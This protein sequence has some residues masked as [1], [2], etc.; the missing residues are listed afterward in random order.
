MNFL[1]LIVLFLILFVLTLLCFIVS[2][3]KYRKLRSDVS[4]TYRALRR[5]RYGDINQRLQDLNNKKLEHV[6][7][8]LF[9]T[10]CDR[11]SMIKEYQM[12]LSKK[13]LSLEE[14]LKEEKELQLFKEEFAA[15]LTHDMKV[16]VIAEL[17]SLNYLLEGRFGELNEK[18]N[19]ILKLMKASNQELKELIE[20]MLET[21]RLEQKSI[22]LNKIKNDLNPFLMAIIDEMKQIAFQTKNSLVVNF[23]KTQNLCFEFDSFQVKRVIKNLIQNAISFSP[24]ESEIVIATDIS[25]NNLKVYVTN[26]GVGISSEDLDLIFQKYY[27]GHS[28]FRKAGTGLGLYLA[29]QIILAHNGTIE[30]DTTKENYTTFILTIPIS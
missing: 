2:F 5:V 6:I 30:V 19:A 9:E 22:T 4:K 3:V 15:T 23:E 27:S 29:Q 7:N 12:T 20:N 17:N 25:E 1:Y 24:Y 11:E 18:Q 10:I 8:R 13:N 14:I 28:K 26:K 21:Y 16:P